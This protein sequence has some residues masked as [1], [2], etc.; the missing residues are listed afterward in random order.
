MTQDLERRLDV[1]QE[2]C[3]DIGLGSPPKGEDLGLVSRTSPC[4]GSLA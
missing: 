3:V 4:F 2:I 1:L